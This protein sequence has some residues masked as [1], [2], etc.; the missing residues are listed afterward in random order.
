VSGQAATVKRAPA[1]GSRRR[2]RPGRYSRD[3]IAQAALELVD[4]EGLEALTMQRLAREVEAGTMTL[5]G[6]FESRDDLLDA[7]VDVAVDPRPWPAPRGDDWREQLGHTVRTV[8]KALGRHPAIAEIRARRPVLRPEALRFAERVIGL[9]RGAGFEVEEAA[10]AF[11]M[12]FTY[13]FGFAV[14]SPT[15]SSEDARRAA[16]AAA[17]GLPPEQYPHLTEH[18]REWT[19]AMAGAEQF[20]YGLERL[21]DGLQARLAA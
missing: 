20:D 10:S 21:L 8:F 17:A 15:R 6:Y 13:T 1:A 16:R 19:E 2:G 3:Q 4:R 14:L 5:Y 12:I 7:I 11:R 18:V 9:L